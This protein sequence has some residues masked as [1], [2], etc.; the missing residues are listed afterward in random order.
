[1]AARSASTRTPGAGSSTCDRRNCGGAGRPAGAARRAAAR[2]ERERSRGDRSRQHAQAS[3]P[4]RAGRC[5]FAGRDDAR[6]RPERRPLG[7]ERR[8]QRPA[9]AR[10][11]A[12]RRRM[13]AVVVDRRPGARLQRTRRRPPSD[14]R[15]PPA[16]RALGADRTEQREEWSP[17]VSSTGQLAFVSTRGGTPAIYVSRT[18]GTGV[19]AF[20][21]VP[22]AVPPTDIRDLAWSP[23]ASVSRT[24]ARPQTRRRPRRRRRDDAGRPDDGAGGGRASGLVADRDAN[25]LRRRGR[26]AALGRRG[27]QRSARARR[28]RPL[29]MAHRPDRQ[30]GVSEPRAASAVRARRHGGRTR[31]VAAG[32]HVDGRQPR[33]G[34]PLDPGNAPRQLTRDGRAATHHARGGG[35]R[36]LPESG[37]LHYT[38]AP[39]HYHWHFLGFDHYEL[40]SAGAY[41]LVVRDHKSGFCIAD[42]YGIAQGV[43]HGPPRFLA[44]CAQFDP[45]AR[46]VEEG[47]SVGYT[48]RY[49]ANFHGQNLDLTKRAGRA[50]TGSCIEPTPTSICARRTTATTQRR[51]SC[52]SRG[53][54]GVAQRRRCRR[55]R[56]CSQERC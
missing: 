26:P 50:T 24:R 45:R 37:E 19:A 8:R 33:A 51:C 23:T 47:S 38:V 2:R 28:R 6:V 10:D 21:A 25:R 1:M 40:R 35:T 11:D 22:P 30:A 44:N 31:T 55:L 56:V 13:G 18:D 36:I 52:A 41:A 14:P 17:A 39:P 29:Q 27:R 46:F 12:E 7:G 43:P 48:D 34:D 42:H 53:R 16:H 15:H 4:R 32:V 54:T 9:P 49:P 5:V 3:A 20:D